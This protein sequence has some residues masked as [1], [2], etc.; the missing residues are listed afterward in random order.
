MVAA[1]KATAPFG[2][3][4]VLE[5]DGVMY[6]Q[7]YSIAKCCAKLGGMHPEDPVAA[8][9]VEQ[10]VD[11]TD[12]VRSKYV[13]TRYMDISPEE[14]I[15]KYAI[16]FGT[17][18]PP[19]L[20]NLNRA[21]QGKEYYVGGKLSLADIAVTNLFQQL[22][23]PNCAVQ[24][25]SKEMAGM[26]DSA[27]QAFPDLIALQARVEADPKIA[28]YLSTRHVALHGMDSYLA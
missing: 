5:V 6:G 20:A 16:F 7:S 12:D 4:P 9:A 28:A 15:K 23:L 27:C 18:L 10:I 13:P 22:R 2:Q 11:T 1:F 26:G 21:L 8:L 19:L 14:K 3:L 25:E 17:T 24:L